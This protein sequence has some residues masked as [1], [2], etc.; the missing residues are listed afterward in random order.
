[1]NKQVKRKEFY[2]N[3]KFKDK[4][5][6]KYLRDPIYY[7]AM[8][9]NGLFTEFKN[10][11][12]YV[13]HATCKRHMASGKGF[14]VAY[15]VTISGTSISNIQIEDANGNVF[16]ISLAPPNKVI[17]FENDQNC[18]TCFIATFHA[19][20]EEKRFEAKKICYRVKK[21]TF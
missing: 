15:P 8:Q 2:K 19:E 18:L 12:N 9:T 21:L 7:F 14:S 10:I 13:S 3:V 1:M 20:K 16:K 5:S 11:T 4:D 17:Y 6:K